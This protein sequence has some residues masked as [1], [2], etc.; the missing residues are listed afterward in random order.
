MCSHCCKPLTGTDFNV[1][2]FDLAPNGLDVDLVS[3]QLELSPDAHP[4]LTPTLTV[5]TPT[6]TPTA[7]PTLNLTPTLTLA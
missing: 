3:L 7:T 6:P 4:D 1:F 5:P 2:R